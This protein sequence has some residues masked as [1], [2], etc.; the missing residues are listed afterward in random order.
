[1]ASDSLYWSS[2]T[3]GGGIRFGDL[4]GSGA[5]DLVTGESSPEG[6]AIDSA[7]GKIY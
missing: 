5:H 7:A 1:M 4:G 2:Y 6:V 3:N